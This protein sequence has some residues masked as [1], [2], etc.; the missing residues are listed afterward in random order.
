[1]ES[2]QCSL[3]FVHPDATETT[4]HKGDTDKVDRFFEQSSTKIAS[5]RAQHL[6][7]RESI[8]T[9]LSVFVEGKCAMIREIISLTRSRDG[10]L[11]H[12]SPS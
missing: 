10:S 2:S 4:F 12:S 6:E 5:R 3:L 9:F 7:L 8:L 11:F 1:M